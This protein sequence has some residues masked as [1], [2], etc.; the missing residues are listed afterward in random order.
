MAILK[1]TGRIYETKPCPF[2]GGEDITLQ[3][4]TSKKFGEA[5]GFYCECDYCRAHLMPRWVSIGATESRANA[6]VA[7]AITA[8]ETRAEVD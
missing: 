3:V 1:I 4:V 5:F 8:W 2:C 6:A 7:E